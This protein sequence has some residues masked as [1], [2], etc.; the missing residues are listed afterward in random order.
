MM[1]GDTKLNE[2]ILKK[3]V[4]HIDMITRRRNDLDLSILAMAGRISTLQSKLLLMKNSPK[5]K[6]FEVFGEYLFLDG[7]LL[8]AREAFQLSLRYEGN[9]DQRLNLVS[10]PSTI[11]KVIMSRAIEF[12]YFSSGSCGSENCEP[13]TNLPLVT[14]TAINKIFWPDTVRSIV[15]EK[16]EWWLAKSSPM[17]SKYKSLKDGIYEAGTEAGVYLSRYV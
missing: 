8:A 17:A 5:E 14:K 12:E 4:E 1:D 15:H 11:I 13:K 10:K 3:A 2:N 6:L 7:K 16:L 9:L